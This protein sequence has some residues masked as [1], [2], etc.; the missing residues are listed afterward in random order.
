M[1]LMGL[2]TDISARTPNRASTLRA[3]GLL[4]SRSFPH[5][6]VLADPQQQA[7]AWQATRCDCKYGGPGAGEKTGCPEMRSLYA[8]LERLD[9]ERWEAMQAE[10]LFASLQGGDRG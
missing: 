2:R 10:G 5:V 3:L 8:M 1:T 6:P 4:G 9:D 7:K